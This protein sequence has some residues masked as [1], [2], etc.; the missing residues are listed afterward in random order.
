MSS[1]AF[2]VSRKSG[3]YVKPSLT[4][5]H[6]RQTHFGVL[7]AVVVGFFLAC[8]AGLVFLLLKM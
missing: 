5:S 4:P 1:L 7:D 6:S 8:A 3:E 2:K